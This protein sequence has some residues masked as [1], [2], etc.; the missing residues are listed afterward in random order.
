MKRFIHT[1]LFYFFTVGIAFGQVDATL[2]VRLYPI[3][4][5][6]VNPTL[7][8]ISVDYKTT[9]DNSQDMMIDQPDYLRMF[10][11]GGFVVKVESTSTYLINDK[12]G[13]IPVSD[14]I[15]SPN[16][17][18]INPLIEANLTSADL[19]ERA[20]TIIT[21]NTGAINKTFGIHYQTKGDYDYSDDSTTENPSTVVTNII[22]SI[23]T[24]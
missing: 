7:E 21:N 20:S 14:I 5:I 6:E 16:A 3:Q 4:V 8:M 10:S 1:V 23:E 22:Y 19:N 9:E 11:T 17:G 24:L 13:G 12:G 15:I 18:A 2:N